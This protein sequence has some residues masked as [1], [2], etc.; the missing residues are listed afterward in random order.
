MTTDQIM[1]P[2]CLTEIQQTQL[3]TAQVVDCHMHFLVVAESE[4]QLHLAAST[5]QLACWRH[6]RSLRQN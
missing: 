5:Q 4:N 6:R 3:A 2:E 1:M